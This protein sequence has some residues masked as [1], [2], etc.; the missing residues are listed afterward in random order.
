M[1]RLRVPSRAPAPPIAA[2]GLAR[3][4]PLE[5]PTPAVARRFDRDVHQI[6][7]DEALPTH[8]AEDRQRHL[9]AP[10]EIAEPA[11]MPAPEREQDTR[12]A[13]AEEPRVGADAALDDDAGADPRAAER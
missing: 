3:Q 8:L 6:A 5:R 2:D 13:L 9:L 10:C 7:D 1:F 4:S 11:E 12:L